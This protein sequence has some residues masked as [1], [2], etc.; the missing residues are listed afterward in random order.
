MY[1]YGPPHMAVQKQD[2]QHEH[3]FSSYVR[4]RDVVLK[5]YLG[6]WMIGRSGE[7]GSGISV[8]PARWWWW[9]WWWRIDTT[10]QN[11]KC[12]LCG[13]RDEMI[14]HIISEC[15]KLRKNSLRLLTTGWKGDYQGIVQEIEI[16]PYEQAIYAQPRIRLGKRDAQ[17][18]LRFMDTNGSLY[19]GLTTRPT[20]PIYQPLRSGKIWHMVNF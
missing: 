7:R 12:R 3:T 2:D 5:T 6:R 20:D 9:W 15:K 16:W 4:I 19:L 11:S 8:L 1:S 13:D 10:Q 14:I 17:T 18:S